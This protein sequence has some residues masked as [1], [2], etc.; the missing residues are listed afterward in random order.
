MRIAFVFNRKK[1]DSPAQAEFDTPETICAIHEALASGGHEVFDIEMSLEDSFSGW[2]RKLTACEPDV[3]FNTAEGFRGSARE[4]VAPAIFEQLRL[5][6]IGSGPHA[7]LLTMD[8]ALTKRVVADHDVPVIEG[9][10][11]R[12]EEDFEKMAAGAAYPSFVKPNFE[13]SSKG[14]SARSICHSA[15][16][17]KETCRALLDDFPEG[18]LVERY[19]EGRDL[20]VSY[21]SGLGN[22]GILE[23]VEY[24]YADYGGKGVTIC[25]ERLKNRAEEDVAVRCATRLNPLLGDKVQQM[26]RRIVQATGVEDFARADFRLADSG[27]LYFLEINAMPSLQPGAGLFAATKRLGLDYRETILTILEAGLRRQGFIE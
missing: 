18:V 8:K 5:P 10:L 3:I 13:G 17:L 21:I 1:D 9:S 12:N 25:D 7:C 4:S 26:T 23:P 24:S 2:L 11:V 27:E 22:D 16:R 6:F 14:I 19:V 20:A 15:E